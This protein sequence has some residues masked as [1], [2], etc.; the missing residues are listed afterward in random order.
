[1][2]RIIDVVEFLDE[3]GQEIVH[4][5]PEGGP[6][7]LRLGSQGIVRE[8]Q[9]AVF[10]RDGRA[11]DVLGPGRHTLTTANVPLL[12]NLV[13]LATSGRTPFPAEVVFVNMR[14]FVDQKWGTPEPLPFRDE[15]FGMARLRAFGTYA[16]QVED[17]PRFVNQ[18]AGQQGVFNT[19]EIQGY[20]RGI[21]VQRFTDTLAGMHSS[22]LDLP[23]M[24]GE[25]ASSTRT[26]LGDDFAALGLSL[27][28][29]YVNAIT[30][31]EETSRAIDE[32]ASMGAIGDMDT[33][34]KFKAARAL[35]D[36]A[37]NPSGGAGAGVGLGAGI[38]LGAG[39]AGMLGQAFQAG[40]QPAAPA[41]ASDAGPITRDQVQQA[42]DALDL[43]F[44]KGEISEQ[45]YTR[46]MQKWETRLK[47]LGG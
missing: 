35:G 37:L 42:I 21:I 1:M 44:S 24:Y 7:D 6:G 32:R 27:V 11:L 28:A 9:R 14:Q 31:T 19:G 22:V 36:A 8:S 20:L 47:E 41:A 26:R 12:A 23:G 10:F 33:Y 13:G 5:E 30:P 2:A 16:F 29:F 4:R 43:R 34:L 39:M 15:S 17:P 45:M 46:L 18:I 3:T 38:G 25:I 40:Q